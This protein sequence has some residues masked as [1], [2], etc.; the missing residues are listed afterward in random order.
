ME[1]ILYS[2]LQQNGFDGITKAA[3]RMFLDAIDKHLKTLFHELAIHT[4]IGKHNEPTTEDV[5]HWFNLSNIPVSGLRKELQTVYKPLSKD[6]I[7]NLEERIHK[8]ADIPDRFK[9][10]LDSSMISHLLGSL[11]VSQNRP[12]YVASHLPPF[13][14][15]HTYLA[16][17]V[18]P[19]RPTS[20]RRIR[21]LA[22]KESRLAE[23]ALRKILDA[24]Q[25]QVMNS[26][27]Q[28]A[29]TKACQDLQLDS[30]SFHIVNWESQ[31]WNAPR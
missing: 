21:E 26:P 23:N 31:K 11:A 30:K 20:P 5:A 1:A 7:K 6:F 22:T 4:Q 3:E 24:N 12:N 15:S 2:I 27:R 18:Y 8:S 10:S 16:S 13:P 14:A 25:P 19:V 9:S 17:P 29:F 28:A